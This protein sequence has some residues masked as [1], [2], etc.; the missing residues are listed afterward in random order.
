MRNLPVQERGLLF[1]RLCLVGSFNHWSLVCTTAQLLD[2]RGRLS[3]HSEKSTWPVCWAGKESVGHIQGTQWILVLNCS[4]CTYAFCVYVFICVF[5]WS[6]H[7]NCVIYFSISKMGKKKR[8][9]YIHLA[10]LPYAVSKCCLRTA[11][12]ICWLQK[13]WGLCVVPTAGEL[14]C[15]LVKLLIDLNKAH[16]FNWKYEIQHF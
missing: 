11:D 10:Y 16:Y 7:A 3:L 4:I 8:N 2:Y 6:Y 13:W 15:K 9:S 1:T 5:N 14:W 12:S